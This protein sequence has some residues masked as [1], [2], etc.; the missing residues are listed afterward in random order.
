MHLTWLDNNG[1][2]I[3]L[4][5]QRILLDPWLVEPLVF[6]G[7]DWLFKQERRSPMPIPE[8]IDLLLLSQ[9]LEDHAHPPTLKQLDRQIPVV[10]SPNAAKVVTELG[11][12]NV[13]VLN[14]GESF[15]LTESVTI[16]AIEGDPIGPFVLENAYILREGTASDNQDGED[17]ISSIYYDPHGYHYESLKAEKPIDVVI[18]PLMGIS[19]P[20]LG[21]VVKGA[22]SAIDAVDLLRPKLIIPTASGSDAKMTGVLTR[23]LKADGG[24]EKLKNLAAARN[25]TV[26]VIEPKPGDRF[27]PALAVP[28]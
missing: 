3:E 22:D 16:K 10:A 7:M 12:G 18:T 6:G 1:W 26:Q 25:L 13:T 15:N 21:P 2:L 23:V 4:G 9:G 28:V 8:N 5:G 11:F 17:R 20:L 19:I 14:H 27:S 24:A